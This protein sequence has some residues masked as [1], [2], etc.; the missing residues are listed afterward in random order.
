[1]AM[2]IFALY[3]RLLREREVERAERR[4]AGDVKAQ[5]RAIAMGFQWVRGKGGWHSR[6]MRQYE[7]MIMPQDDHDV[8]SGRRGWSLLANK[9]L[10]PADGG[11]E[12]K[13]T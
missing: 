11:A 7:R 4:M 6:R 12:D 9:E 2:N 8:G 5:E 3:E 13:K 10:V 1:M